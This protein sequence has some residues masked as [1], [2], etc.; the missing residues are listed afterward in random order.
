VDIAAPGEDVHVARAATG[1]TPATATSPGEGTS[2]ATTAIAGAA[3]T[4]I[5][6]HGEQAIKDAQPPGVSRSELFLAAVQESAV[7]GR[8]AGWESDEYGAGIL[9]LDA[10]L[11][12]PLV[13]R[14]SVAQ[15]ATDLPDELIA[16]ML[17]RER[18]W[19]RTALGD[20][21]GRPADLDAELARVG[22][23]L[24]DVAARD[25]RS[26]E[27]LLETAAPGGPR[28]VERD[29][30]RAALAPEMSRT[31]SARIADR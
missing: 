8:P 22:G 4:W 11:A 24:L 25:P 30:A 31:L 2:Y 3:A 19:T 27:T 1:T 16:R 7:P 5:A 21:L 10:L 15:S 23:E 12:W 14:R 13:S 26:F 6:F 17:G 18:Q 29:A 28:S 9:D 20:L